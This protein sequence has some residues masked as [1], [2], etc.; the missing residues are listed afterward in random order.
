MI[1]F[2]AIGGRHKNGVAEIWIGT[3]IETARTKSQEAAPSAANAFNMTGHP[4]HKTP[5]GPS[6]S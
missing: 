2:Y 6:W 1:K 5:F 3:I 4:Q